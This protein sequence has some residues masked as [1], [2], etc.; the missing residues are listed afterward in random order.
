MSTATTATQP[1]DPEHNLRVALAARE[2]PRRPGPLTASF[3]HFWRAMLAFKHGPAQ[4]ID[5]ILFPFVF[6][7]V[8]TYLFGGA[9]EGSTGAYLQDFL[10][11]VLVQT[12]VMMSV[13]TGTAVSTDIAKGIHD[14]FRTLPFWQPATIVGNVLGDMVR[15]TIALVM[16]VAIGLLLGFRPEAGV[17]GVVL[18]ILVLIMFAFSVSWIFTAL[19]VVASKPESVSSTSMIVL[20]PLVFT[21]NI[22]VPS[23]TMPGWMQAIVA[24]NPISHAATAS[25]GLMHG[26]I[27]AGQ[28]TLVVAVS[29]GITVVFAPLTMYLYR[30]KNDR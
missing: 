17:I 28:L 13:Y 24:V 12:V 25:R 11:G 29:L 27:T 2:R 18:T 21:S 3:T 14:R 16:T 5:M 1:A 8:F 9:I 20:F 22:F 30:S 19:G 23:G 7:L 6:L 26:T 10:P 4:L 15:Y